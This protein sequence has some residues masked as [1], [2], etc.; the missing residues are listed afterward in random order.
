MTPEP[1]FGSTVTRLPD[2]P[3]SGTVSYSGGP[4]FRPLPGVLPDVSG[5]DLLA[6]LGR[7]GMGVVYWARDRNLNREVALKM[8]LGG[9]VAGPQALVRFLAE[10]EAL[11]ALHHPHVVQVYDRGQ[12]QGLPFFAMEYCPGGS[13]AAKVKDNPLPA[14]EAAALIEKLARGVAAAHAAGILHRDLKPDNVLLA[15]DGTPKLT[16]FGLA[17]RFDDLGEAGTGLTHTGAV[18]GTPSYMA[19]EQAKGEAKAVG[20]AADVYGLGALMYRLVTGRP[21]FLGATVVE[22]VRQVIEDDPVSPTILTPGLSRDLS[23]ICLK[24]LAKDPATRYAGA[25]ELA[26]DLRRYL[27]GRTILARP[28]RAA[29]RAAKW[30]KRNPVVTGATAAV[31]LALAAGTVV[32]WMMYRDAKVQERIAEDKAKEAEDRAK[33]RDI[34]LDQAT[35]ALRRE[36]ERAGERDAAASESRKQ[37]E[38]AGAARKAEADRGKE[39]DDALGEARYQLGIGNFLLAN[40][41]FENRDPGLARVRLDQV[42][43]A[44]RRWEWHYL[45]RQIE[46]GLFTLYGHLSPVFSVAVS[47]D[48]SRIVTGSQ[49]GTARVWDARSGVPVLLLRHL[50]PV[51]GVAVSPDGTRIVTGSLD[52]TARIWDARTGVQLRVLEHTFGVLSVALSPDGTRVVT[53]SG[54]KTVRVWD[55]Q[56]GL[57]W[58][59]LKGHMDDVFGVAVSPDGTRV[60]TGSTDKTARVWDART[61]DP[62]LI[63]KHPGE[64]LGVAVSPDGARVVTGCHDGTARVW[65]A[66]TGT[67]LLELKGPAAGIWGVAVSPD[68]TRIVG[69]CGDRTARVWDAQSGALLLELVGHTGAVHGTAFSPD[70]TRVVT[71]SSDK[72]AKIWDARSGSPV[73]V[74]VGHVD[75]IPGAAFSRDGTRVSTAGRDQTVR[76][77]DIRTGTPLSN[78]IGLEKGVRIAAFSPDGTRVV[79]GGHDGTARIW[80][81]QVGTLVAVM[82]GHE[83][84]VRS[85]A[86]SPD[87]TWVVTASRD[88]TARVWEARTG[89]VVSTLAAHRD[90]VTG[91][92]FSP[93]GTRIVTTSCD[94]TALVWDNRSGPPH[95]AWKKEDDAPPSWRNRS[96]P[97][98]FAWSHSDQVLCAAFSADGKRIITGSLDKTAKVWDA[99]TGARLLDLAGHTASVTS[100][101]FSPEGARIITASEDGTAKVWDA[102]TGTPL[103]NLA[104]QAVPVT[105]AAVSPD[106]ARIVT[107]SFDGTIRVWDG[108]TDEQLIAFE[109]SFYRHFW[110]RPDLQGHREQFARATWTGAPF[111]AAFHLDRLLAYAPTERPEWL[112]ERTKRQA[113]NPVLT[114]RTAIHS[115]TIAKSDFGPVALRAAYGDPLALRLV[116]GLL[117]RNGEPLKAIG[118]LSVALALRAPGRPPVEELL[119][120]LAHAKSG[121]TD[122]A[123]TWHSTAI[124][125]LD[126]YQR[127]LQV[128]SAVGTASTDGWGAML[129][130]VRDQADPRYNPFDWETWY[131]CQVFRA[132]VEGLL[133]NK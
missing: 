122:E 94:K 99:E 28:V 111:A 7:G 16:D 47:P 45:N 127:P 88:K 117:I 72:V 4:S 86:F 78:P 121:R 74:L 59:E 64:V 68:G 126:R 108:Q 52:R 100:A 118:P 89:A 124:T 50:E 85:V 92:T 14:R 2:G 70:G 133:I 10:A 43:P 51:F 5:Y 21:P 131:E 13:L 80:D 104:K 48:G 116:G 81:T 123:K 9:A 55:V 107:S 69:G 110:T 58:V 112:V 93:D 62:V 56:T 22:T 61:G 114:A 23:T 32:S 102:R 82:E 119:L 120:A 128:T 132:E 18:L 65:D 101:T 6:E 27:D 24:C 38:Q 66:R 103:L 109:E 8:I 130:L 12:C 11:A 60:I 113:D 105:G 3:G 90:E 75:P 96:G 57:V 49:D 33:E 17:K 37:H 83:G 42:P 95:F 34:A 129:E 67:R 1:P 97:P 54:D 26:D 35:A 20:P 87:G 98:H 19:P 125:W 106:G 25:A 36:A 91:A 53:G 73:T 31:V 39:R 15:A 29:E 30:V 40:A 41:A 46:G 71:A 76:V 84:E 44:Q 115:P 77:W 79:T 63:L